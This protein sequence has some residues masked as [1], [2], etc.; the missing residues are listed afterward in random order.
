[1]KTYR[2]TWIDNAPSIELQADGFT[3]K[4]DGEIKFVMDVETA[5]PTMNIMESLTSVEEVFVFITFRE[6]V[7]FISRIGEE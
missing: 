4:K 2:I 1:M 3:I 5:I 6:K 7:R